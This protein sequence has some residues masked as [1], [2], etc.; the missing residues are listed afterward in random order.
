MMAVPA[1]PRFEGLFRS[2]GTFNSHPRNTQL[3]I[4]ATPGSSFPN[5]R[6]GTYRSWSVL[7]V[8]T[9]ASG[10]NLSNTKILV[11]AIQNNVNTTTPDFVPFTA[12]GGDPGLKYYRSHYLQSAVQPNNGL[13]GQKESGGDVGGCIE[14]VGPA[15]G[16][17][18]CHQ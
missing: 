12:V 9:D 7:R 1:L 18:S 14:P 8:V 15:P 10:I 2:A 13:S 16:V 3:R 4:P 17:L 5:L 11:N 6:N